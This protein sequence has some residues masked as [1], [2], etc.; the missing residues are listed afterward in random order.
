MKSKRL[1]LMLIILLGDYAY[2]DEAESVFQIDR[3][4]MIWNLDDCKK[5]SDASGFFLYESGK[6]L[7]NLEKMHNKE[8]KKTLE[9]ALKLTDMA[10]NY[11]KNFEVYCN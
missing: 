9:Y 1:L 11:A 5:V 4:A 3:S 10:A 6:V 2:S 8:K 7:E